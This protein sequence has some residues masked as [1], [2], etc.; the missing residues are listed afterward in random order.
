VR[1]DLVPKYE[2]LYQGRAYAPNSERRRIG[3]LV[4]AT[5][6][7]SDPRF[8]RRERLARRRRERAEAAAQPEPE[9]TA[10]F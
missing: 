3:K 2:D 9:Q 6:A 10:L 1:P 4:R 5:N 7:S 8:S